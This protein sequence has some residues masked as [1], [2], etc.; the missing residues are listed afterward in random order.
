VIRYDAVAGFYDLLAGL[1]GLGAI[2][3]CKR[4]QVA[5][6]GRGDRVLF[7]GAGT[8]AEA[9][10]AA[11][12]GADVTVIDLAPAMADRARARFRAAG[13]EGAI[14]VLRGDVL[15][16]HEVYDAVAAHFFLNVF[17]EPV[18]GEVLAHMAGRVRPGG[19]LLIADFSPAR[20]PGL[21]LRRLYFAAA[22][23]A[24]R[25]LA[26]NPLHRLYDYGP[27]LP[28]AGLHL[29]RSRGFGP[30]GGPPEL[31]RAWEAV[32]T[33]Q[34]LANVTSMLSPSGKR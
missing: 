26:G 22:V 2:G 7:A 24:F 34:D 32:R 19:R 3:A 27:L 16:H 17:P 9:L 14:R 13:M 20:G 23:L 6:L 30:M 5:E 29:E 31:F 33:D 10:L 11:R 12:R 8:G 18:L 4:S 15:E 25:A 1:Y 28:G 21:L